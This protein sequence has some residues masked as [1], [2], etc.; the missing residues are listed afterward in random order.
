MRKKLE[1]VSSFG[2]TGI[3][4]AHEGLSIFYPSAAISL[5]PSDTGS[6]YA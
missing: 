6:Q 4:E 2:G 5:E 3:S 1:A